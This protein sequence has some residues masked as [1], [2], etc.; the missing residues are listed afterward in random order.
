MNNKRKRGRFTSLEEHLWHY[1]EVIDDDTSCWEW[2]G[3]R[4]TAGYGTFRHDKIQYPAHRLM[5]ELHNG[6]EPNSIRPY[7]QHVLHK[8][9]NPPCVRP[10]H[11]ALGTASDNMKDMIAKGRGQNASITHCPHGHEYT[12][13]NSMMKNINGGVWRRCRTCNNINRRRRYLAR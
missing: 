3:T 10:D 7:T 9:D 1:V 2:S 6:L 13:E 11:L 4:I 5:Y 8:C 12:P